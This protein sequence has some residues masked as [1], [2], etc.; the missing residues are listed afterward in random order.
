MSTAKGPLIRRILTLAH[1]HDFEL[2]GCTLIFCVQVTS[3]EC[4]DAFPT[5]PNAL[6][7]PYP[8]QKPHGIPQKGICKDCN[9]SKSPQETVFQAA[10]N[11][12]TLG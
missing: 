8:P 3:E 1:M 5:A 6:R 2:F 10:L 7:I 9:F 4:L 12:N 11:P